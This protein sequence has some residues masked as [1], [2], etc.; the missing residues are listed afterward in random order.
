[1]SLD[2]ENVNEV[3]FVLKLGQNQLTFKKHHK[4]EKPKLNIP[5]K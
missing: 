1:M 5:E 3:E 2:S 4:L